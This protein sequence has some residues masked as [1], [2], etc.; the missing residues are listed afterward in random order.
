MMFKTLGFLSLCL[1]CVQ[2]VSLAQSIDT[3]R[4]RK[5]R[6]E[7]FPAE[8]LMWKGES[9]QNTNWNKITQTPDGRIWFCG[10]DHWGVDEITGP[11]SKAETYERPWGFGN[12]AVS[13]YDPQL[14]R[15]FA[16]EDEDGNPLEFDRAS[17]LYANAETPGHGKSHSNIASDSKGRIY[18]AGYMGLS[19]NH[20]YTRAY[21]PKSYAGGALVRYDPATKDVD[22][23]GI[24][25]PNGGI[26]GIYYDEKRNILNGITVDR[27]KF[28]RVNLRTMELNRYESIARMSRVE[29]RVREMIMD[30][31][32]FCY[33]ANDVG[34]ITKF[35]PDKET[36]TD[37]DLTLPGELMDFRATVVSSKNVI[38]GITTDGFVWSYDAP[39]GRMENYGHVIG[40]PGRGHYTPNIALDEEWGRLYFLAGNHGGDVVESA[41]EVL[42][43]LDLKSKK[44]YWIG[45]AEGVEGCFGAVVGRDHT[46]YFSG[47]GHLFKNNKVVTD[48]EG[49]PVTRPYLIRYRP[50]QALASL[51][52]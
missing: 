33:F 34:G 19:Y 8:G 50:P 42:T 14:N 44:F 13:Y 32:G 43:I 3:T 39:N 31:A 20:E 1:C 4:L 21:Y 35:D 7:M 12:T 10:G 40:M 29:D 37:L 28:F 36:F 24:P 48:K 52:Q 6:L 51:A 47:F 18:F 30:K 46:V 45:Q 2:F 11:W 26:V 17:A 23:F 22:Y 38:Y 25:F 27:A 49:K 41:L 9:A 15:S 16:A 5:M